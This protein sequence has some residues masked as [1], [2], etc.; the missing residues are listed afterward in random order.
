LP[1]A[2]ETDGEG[3]TKSE[4]EN[5]DDFPDV[6]NCQAKQFSSC[7]YKLVECL[8]KQ[9]PT[10]NFAIQFGYTSLCHHPQRRKIIEKI[11]ALNYS[12]IR[13]E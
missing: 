7:D 2:P 6:E 5:V 1:V 8:A 4:D 11:N 3:M 12:E 10:C 13:S 9:H